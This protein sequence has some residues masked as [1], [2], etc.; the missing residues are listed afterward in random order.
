MLHARALRRV[1]HLRERRAHGLP[2]RTAQAIGHD[3]RV[4]GL[5]LE[6]EQGAQDEGVGLPLV[7]GHQVVDPRLRP[8][9]GE[10][11]E[12]VRVVE[13]A[14]EVG[15]EARPIVALREPHPLL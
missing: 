15:V 7:P 14:V 13:D 12:R 2:V 8:R 6:R 9:R 3:D 10:R 4:L 1:V 5:L 11:A